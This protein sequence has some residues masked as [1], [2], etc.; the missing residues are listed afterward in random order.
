MSNNKLLKRFRYTCIAASYTGPNLHCQRGFK[1]ELTEDDPRLWLF[2]NPS[3]EE[4]ELDPTVESTT[5]PSEPSGDNDADKTPAEITGD[6][7]LEDL[8]V[9]S[10]P[11]LAILKKAE[12]ETV[13]DVRM[14]TAEDLLA[15]SGI[16]QA[17]VDKLMAAC[18][19]A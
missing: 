17:T 12:Y 4:K 2:R 14:S 9:L 10:K 16:G 18:S 7:L 6:T 3:F 8:G 13:E 5:A 11:I 1:V 19:E 15:I